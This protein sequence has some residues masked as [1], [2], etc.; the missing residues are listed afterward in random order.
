MDK[1]ALVS[2]DEDP[3]II[4]ILDEYQLFS[5][6]CI[7]PAV[8]RY[9]LYQ[10]SLDFHSKIMKQLEDLTQVNRELEKQV[11]FKT[12]QMKELYDMVMEQCYH[13]D[14]RSH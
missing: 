1:L 9:D 2:F 11:D 12:M 10:L 4:S 6:A 8:S 3:Q 14:K 13:T 5:A 7:D